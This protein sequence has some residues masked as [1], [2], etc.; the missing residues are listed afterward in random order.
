MVLSIVPPATSSSC[1]SLIAS[2]LL[3]SSLILVGWVFGFWLVL[4]LEYLLGS[5]DFQCVSVSL[6]SNGRANPISNAL[7]G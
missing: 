6:L 7:E 5:P 1:S 2:G 4:V 3:I